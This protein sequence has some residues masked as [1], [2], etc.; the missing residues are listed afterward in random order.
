M[1]LKDRLGG[2]GAAN[3]LQIL[4]TVNGLAPCTRRDILNSLGE[5]P[6]MLGAAWQR[7]WRALGWLVRAGFVTEIAGGPGKANMYLVDKQKWT[8]FLEQMS[9]LLD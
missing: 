9:Q 8:R 7:V 2:L 3:R 6:E 4:E 5:D 1:N